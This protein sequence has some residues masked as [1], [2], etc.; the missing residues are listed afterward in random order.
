[1]LRAVPERRVYL[2][3]DFPNFA[4]PVFDPLLIEWFAELFQPETMPRK[5]RRDLRETYQD[6]YAHEL[7]DA[8]IDR[9]INLDAN[10]SSAF[11][12][13]FEAAR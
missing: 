10:L 13:R 11:Y 6:V 3:P 5:L 9:L 4:S 8:E 12:S 2:A 1:M 7:S